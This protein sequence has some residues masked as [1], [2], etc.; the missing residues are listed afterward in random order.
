MTNL[1]LIGHA[2]FLSMDVPDAVFATCK[3][4]NYMRR[5]TLKTFAFAGFIPVWM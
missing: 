5:E 4:L 3:S 1:T 2:V